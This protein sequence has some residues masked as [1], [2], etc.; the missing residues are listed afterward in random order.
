MR[1]PAPVVLSLL[2][3][4]G[5]LFMP[6]AQAELDCQFGAEPFE[7][8]VEDPVEAS[9]DADILAQTPINGVIP[10]LEQ[11]EPALEL[12]VSDITCDR[13][14]IGSITMQLTNLGLPPI[15]G[16]TNY[17]GRGYDIYGTNEAWAGFIIVRRNGDFQ[18]GANVVLSKAAGTT[19]PRVDLNLRLKYVKLTNPL[20]GTV[21]QL[22]SRINVPQVPFDLS[23]PGNRSFTQLAR[24]SGL[25]VDILGVVCNLLAPHQMD[26][27]QV[28]ISDLRIP[29]K[30]VAQPLLLQM[31]CG[32]GYQMITPRVPDSMQVTF[33]GGVE[34]GLLDT[35]QANVKFGIVDRLGRLLP[36]SVSTPVATLTN[37]GTLT[38][39]NTVRL[40]VRTQLKDI[41]GAA[42]AGTVN[43]N[44]GIQVIYK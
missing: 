1:L 29:G 22:A 28:S 42:T 39:A 5:T 9:L 3:I 44:L 2:L 14:S 32:A 41:T 25:S 6:R 16:T 34:A 7:F 27:G 13:A 21:G 36:F 35:N 24:F 4:G 30:V 19:N 26:L 18:N 38:A 12:A 33:T 8:A 40:S 37:S 15:I 17:N 11:F 23:V 20:T 43:G 31:G 10:N